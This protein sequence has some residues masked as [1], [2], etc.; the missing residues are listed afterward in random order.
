[1]VTL[2]ATTMSH[3]QMTPIGAKRKTKWFLSWRKV[4][5]K[6]ISKQLKRRKT[7]RRMFACGWIKLPQTTTIRKNMNYAPWCSEI[8]RQRRSQDMRS[9]TPYLKLT[10]QNKKLLSKQSSEKLK[11]NMP[12]LTS[13]PSCVLRLYVL[14]SPFKDLTRLEPTR[15]SLFSEINFL[16]TA[17]SPLKIF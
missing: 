5:K 8:E 9:R 14:N 10:L 4:R 3:P 7:T 1:M 11:L 16:S 6:I 2:I 15:R 13:T 12:T 17:D